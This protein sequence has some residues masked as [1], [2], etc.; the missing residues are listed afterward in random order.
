MPRQAPTYIASAG[1][2]GAP[3]K[4]KWNSDIGLGFYDSEVENM[5]LYEAIDASNFKAK[6]AIAVAI[7]EWIVWRFDGHTNL[8]DAH[9][10]VE[11]A[12]ASAIDPAYTKDLMLQMTQD[13]DVAQVEGP[14]E[15]A[16]WLQEEVDALDAN[17]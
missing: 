1:V 15:L 7:T 17:G 8:T 6:M 16:L 12:W 3:I 9:L 11:A 14:L 2:I 5:K 4:Y 13:D 10:R